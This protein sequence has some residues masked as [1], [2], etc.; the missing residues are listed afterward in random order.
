MEITQN[1]WTSCYCHC[2]LSQLPMQHLV[3]RPLWGIIVSKLNKTK[4]IED[5]AQEYKL[6]HPIVKKIL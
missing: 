5:K 3:I 1:V 6:K 2:A 4:G